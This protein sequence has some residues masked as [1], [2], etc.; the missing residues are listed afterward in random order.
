MGGVDPQKL[1]A[2]PGL[3][4]TLMASPLK[5]LNR[6]H[7]P[8]VDALYVLY[9]GN[10]PVSVGCPPHLDENQLRTSVR[11]G[12]S[13][14]LGPSAPSLPPTRPDKARTARVLH[15][16]WIALDDPLMRL[17]L[18]TYIGQMLGVSVSNPR[19]IEAMLNPPRPAPSPQP[20]LETE[21]I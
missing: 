18:E 10:E 13:M 12:V 7:L 15:A 2:L 8:V 14:T 20:V 16:R 5:P 17:L 6:G 9:Q 3:Y 4:K 1:A 11:I 19:L 21:G